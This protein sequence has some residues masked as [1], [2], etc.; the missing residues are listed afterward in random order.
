MRQNVGGYTI[1]ELMIVL[2]ITAAMFFI[3]AGTLRGQQGRTEFDQAIRDVDSQIIKMVN[4]VGTGVYS[5]DGLNCAINGSGRP[6]INPGGSSDQGERQDCLFLGRAF[7]VFTDGANTGI[8]N[9][10]IVLGRR[11]DSSGA[12]VTNLASANPAIAYQNSPNADLTQEI[13]LPAGTRVSFSRYYTRGSN[14]PI[15]GNLVS[16][17]NNPQ[18]YSSTTGALSLINKGYATTNQDKANSGGGNGPV[19]TCISTISCGGSPATDIARWE[20]CIRSGTSDQ[21]ALITYLASSTGLTS[22]YRTFGGS[23]CT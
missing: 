6:Q 20:L 7:H 4:E 9:V 22:D 14:A 10:Y 3:A 18:T 19:A 12:P 17:Y 2:A 1:V 11:V 5:G 15:T 13:N 21:S 23:T 8:V 16:F